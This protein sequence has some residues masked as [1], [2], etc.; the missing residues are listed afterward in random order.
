MVAGDAVAYVAELSEIYLWV[1]VTKH[2]TDSVT[3]PQLHGAQLRTPPID[4][5]DTL[6][7]Q[8]SL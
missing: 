8:T 6:P 3:Q 7:F 5:L 4:T 2:I 1:S